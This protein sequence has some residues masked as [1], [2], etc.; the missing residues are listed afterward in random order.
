[1]NC[2]RDTFQEPVVAV[3]CYARC[4]QGGGLFGFSDDGDMPTYTTTPPMPLVFG[5]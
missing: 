5:R 2:A 3:P 1:M 4:S